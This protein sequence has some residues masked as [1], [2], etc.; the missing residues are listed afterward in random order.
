MYPLAFAV[1]E[2]TTKSRWPTT[3]STDIVWMPVGQPGVGYAKLCSN[4]GAPLC[5]VEVAHTPAGW[6]GKLFWDGFDAWVS[7]STPESETLFTSTWACLHGNGKRTSKKTRGFQVLILAPAHHHFC[8]ILLA[9]ASFA[10]KS[11]IK[12]FQDT[13][14]PLVGGST[15]SHD[16]VTDGWRIGES[17]V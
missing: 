10:A 5:P 12:R 4:Q 11:K 8:H 2:T 15:K 7:Y 14:V 13:P 1:W 17:D 6:L 3:V 9:K 16:K